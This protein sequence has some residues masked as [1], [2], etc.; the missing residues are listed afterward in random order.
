MAN[1]AAFTGKEEEIDRLKAFFEK[2]RNINKRFYFWQFN[3]GKLKFEYE[4]N[5][6]YRKP[7]HVQ[8]HFH[9][10]DLVGHEEPD[11]KKEAFKLYFRNDFTVTIDP[12]SLIPV[13]MTAWREEREG[14]KRPDRA[15][16][17][18]KENSALREE[19]KYRDKLIEE[20]EKFAKAVENSAASLKTSLTKARR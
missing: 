20:H 9:A 15:R 19:I 12:Q 5:L 7:E 2:I 16:E 10:A 4:I 14:A 11:N 8:F 3:T 6:P 18:E 13:A 17:L 1:Y